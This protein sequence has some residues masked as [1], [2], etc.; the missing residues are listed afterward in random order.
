MTASATVREFAS[1]TASLTMSRFDFVTREGYS[2]R[3]PREVGLLILAGSRDTVVHSMRCSHYISSTDNQGNRQDDCKKNV[4]HC[5]NVC[6]GPV[7]SEYFVRF[8][9][10]PS[11]T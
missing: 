2:R 9:R 4:D 1:S 7:L 3:E 11:S 6:A 10:L 8:H 5:E